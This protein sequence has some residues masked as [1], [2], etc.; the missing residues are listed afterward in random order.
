VTGLAALIQEGTDSGAEIV[1][2]TDG[3]SGTAAELT[4]AG[5]R[6]V[7]SEATAPAIGVLMTND[8][9][10][11]EVLLGA[12]ASGASL[13]SL[14]LPGRGADLDAYVAFIRD[15][16][17]EQGVEE[18]V[19]SD[20]VAALVGGNGL[21]LRPHSELSR[22][23][24]ACPTG[25]GFR[26]VQ[27]S[28]GS[29]QHPKPIALDDIALG[30]NV[31]AIL[32]ALQ[33]RP[34]DV[35]VSWLPL[36]HDMGLIG[37]L[38]AGIAGMSR[39]CAG[40]SHLV[41]LEPTRFLRR[42][43]LWLTAVDHWRGTITAAP[44]FGLRVAAQHRPSLQLDLSSLRVVIV[45][46]EVVR[47]DTLATFTETFSDDGLH[48]DGLCPAYGMAEFGL[49]VTLTPP[50]EHWRERTVSTVSL[51]DERLAAP[52]PGV[53][54]MTLVASGPSLAG[55]DVACTGDRR[56]TGAIRVKGP[57]IGMNGR[58]A[59]ALA[60]PDGWYDTGDTGF[61]DA[62][63]LYVCGRADDY[64]V[65]NGRNIYAPAVE[66]AVGEVAGIRSGRVTAVGLPTGEWAIVAEPATK[67]PL[68][69][70]EERE[71]RA[72]IQRA[73]VG[74]T[75][76]RSDHVHVVRRGTLPLTASGKLQRNEMRTR[77]LRGEL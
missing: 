47:A 20:E 1:F 66:N 55:Y 56:S 36:S 3:E 15:V 41:L 31:A 61:T 30:T 39:R 69:A 16:L 46:G 45:G 2:G 57:S 71:L 68:S 25:N 50:G 74:V 9:S 27:F 17:A 70:G 77:I 11:V 6:F 49:A 19:L 43:D 64:I 75:S 5:A 60:E 48:P 28:S 4:E 14:P 67:T 18:I 26:L 35:A 51:A 72:D 38:L 54:A 65:A 76:A 13:V 63:W 44:D 59:A 32:E 23:P 21:P 7:S 22:A 24:L 10:T 53:P 42:P 52:S 29:T 58:T 33:P 37:M 12:I 34:G 73:A 40:P 8:R 62:D